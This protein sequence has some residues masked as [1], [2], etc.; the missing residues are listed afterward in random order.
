LIDKAAALN[1]P[2]AY[3]LERRFIQQLSRHGAVSVVWPRQKT[4]HNAPARR[5]A[6]GKL[7]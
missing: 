7:R 3:Y 1:G 2:K 6:N 4:I 5:L